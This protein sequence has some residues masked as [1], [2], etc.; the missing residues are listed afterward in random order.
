MM[1]KLKYTI[2]PI[3]IKNLDS[4]NQD[5]WDNRDVQLKII[6][7]QEILGFGAW[8]DSVCVGSLHC[9]KIVLPEWDDS[10]FPAYG[11]NRLEDWPLGWPLLAAKAKNITFN[12]PV[13]G[14]SC[15][16]VGRLVNTHHSDPQYLGQGIGKALLAASIDWAKKHE[17]S[18]IIAIGGSK[19]VPEYNVVMGCLPWTTYANS[20][21]RV[22]AFE[23]DGIKAPWWTLPQMNWDSPTIRN[24]IEEALHNK[25]NL[26]NIC[27]RL[28][29]LHLSALTKS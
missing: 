16:H 12:G 17:Y 18:A 9:Y 6:A 2:E 15:F 20:G 25:E 4:V 7:S 29:V 22:A 26:E 3:T 13:W 24:Q 11:K 10:L 1:N 27:A 23:E 28:M 14:H 5:C 21:F 19:I 8:I